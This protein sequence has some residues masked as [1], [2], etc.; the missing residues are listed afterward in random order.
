MTPLNHQ[1]YQFSVAGLFWLTL[2]AALLLWAFSVGW[3]K[4]AGVIALGTAVLF[5]FAYLLLMIDQH[6]G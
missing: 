5:A 4:V 1:R 3:W 2:V 6:R